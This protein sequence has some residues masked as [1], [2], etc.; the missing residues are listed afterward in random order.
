MM[1][2]CGGQ[3][4]DFDARATASSTTAF[5][6][7]PR[8]RPAITAQAP[9]SSITTTR[10][11][12]GSRIESVAIVR[13]DGFGVNSTIAAPARSRLVAGACAWGCVSTNRRVERASTIATVRRMR[14]SSGGAEDLL[15]I[16]LTSDY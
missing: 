4:V 1:K 3:P 7:P 11:K 13:S 10:A 6:A 14:G 16:T 12:R 8:S 2:F 9:P 5:E 15:G